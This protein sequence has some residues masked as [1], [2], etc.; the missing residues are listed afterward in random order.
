MFY[1]GEGKVREANL[2]CKRKALQ[3]TLPR[4]SG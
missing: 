3:A 4:D 1:K 2:L